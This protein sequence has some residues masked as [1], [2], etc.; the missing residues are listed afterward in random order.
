MARLDDKKRRKRKK[1]PNWKRRILI[2]GTLLALFIWWGLQP[3]RG[4]EEYGLCRVFAELRLKY[5]D[6][7][8]ILQQSK[9]QNEQRIYY[10]YVG[11]YGE[12]K[13]DMVGCTFQKNP[14]TGK[15]MLVKATLNRDDLPKSEVKGFND[16]LPY[17][18]NMKVNTILPPKWDGTIEGL[19]EN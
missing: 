16:G 13:I 17:I 18:Q 4:T 5:P 7:M 8:T 3:L 1:K 15:L 19:K 14:S 2:G 12:R 9:F 11:P 10:A 6:T